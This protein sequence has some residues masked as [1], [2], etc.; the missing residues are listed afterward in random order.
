MDARAKWQSIPDSRL[1]K[2]AADRWCSFG[3]YFAMFPVAFARQVIATYSEPGDL[4]LDPFCGRGTSIFCAAECGRDGYGIDINPVAWLYARVKLKPARIKKVEARLTQICRLASPRANEINR[5]PEFFRKCFSRQV[6][7]FLLACRRHLDWRSSAVDATLMAFVIQYLHG[8]ID[9]NNGRPQSLSN[10][11]RQ[12]KSMSQQY[13]LRWWKKN[14]FTNPPK[15]DPAEF[16]TQRIRWRYEKGF[17][18]FSDSIV[19]LGD[20]QTVLNRAA[21]KFKGKCQLLFTSPPYSAV[22]SYYFDQW[23]RL[24]MLGG[25]AIPSRVGA[26]WKSRFENRAEYKNLIE[27]VFKKCAP[28]MARDAVIYVRTDAR[29][30]TRDVTLEALRKAFPD[31][32]P[33]VRRRPFKGDTQT[34]LFG[35]SSKKPGELDIILMP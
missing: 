33:I 30:F 3:P 10:Q 27:T 19:R 26:R 14:G 28:L 29:K 6:L 8:R 35:D 1:E 11:M 25:P 5:L 23:L 18:K 7:E 12:T 21:T 20:S 9:S 2:K 16:L 34:A 31:R 15:V 13:S 24:W 32:H 4:I 22:T 17:P